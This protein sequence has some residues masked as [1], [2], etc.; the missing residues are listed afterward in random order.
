MIE[1]V[2]RHNMW[3]LYIGERERMGVDV[4]VFMSCLCVRLGP[5]CEVL[6]RILSTPLPVAPSAELS[7]PTTP[8][9]THTH[10]HTNTERERERNKCTVFDTIFRLMM[11]CV[12]VECWTDHDEGLVSQCH[13][14]LNFLRLLH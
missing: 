6:P 3:E 14:S 10:T 5:V 2:H 4:E 1:M 11:V 9:S 8:N 13:F 12:C 7:S